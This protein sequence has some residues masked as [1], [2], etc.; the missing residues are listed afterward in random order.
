[1]DGTFDAWVNAVPTN[2]ASFTMQ[3]PSGGP[4]STVT[5]KANVATLFASLGLSAQAGC[6]TAGNTTFSVNGKPTDATFA[7]NVRTHE[8]LHAA[9]HRTGFNSVIVPWDTRLQAAQTASTEFSGATVAAAE[10]ALFRAMGGTPNQIATAQHNEWIRLNNLL[11]AIGTTI[12]TGGAAT[13][14]NSAANATCT[15]SSLDLT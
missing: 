5:P 4:W 7:A 2:R 1:M 3:V 8:D 10:A 11:H 13:P 14:S 9:D 6:A 12:A 15:T